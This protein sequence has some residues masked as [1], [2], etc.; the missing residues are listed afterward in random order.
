MLTPKDY[1][2]PF[3]NFRPHQLET[4]LKIKAAF[5]R[6]IKVVLVQAPTGIGKTLLSVLVAM[7]LELDMIYTCHTKT[8]QQQFMKDFRVIGAEELT[9]RANYPC[10][11]NASMFPTISAEQCTRNSPNCKTCELN[12]G[13]CEPDA[14]GYCPC[15]SD[16]PYEIQKR[17]TLSAPIGVLNIPY[18]LREINPVGSFDGKELIILDEA[19]ETENALLSMIELTV[20]ET[21]MKK[22]GLPQLTSKTKPESWREWAAETLGIVNQ[23]LSSLQDKWGAEDLISWHQLSRLKTKLELFVIEADDNWIYDNNNSFKPI[24][25]NRYAEKYLWSHAKRF[26]G[27]SATISPWRQLCHDL[28]VDTSEVEFIDVPSI[29]DVARY[30]IYYQPVANM[31]RDTKEAEIPVLVRAI[32]RIMEQYPDQKGLIHCVSYDNMYRILNL[33]KYPECM[34]HHVDNNRESQ[35]RQFMSSSQPL[36]LLSP[37]M[38]R[39][40]DL[41]DDYC[42]FI[43]IIKVPFPYLGD[44]QIKARLYQHKSDGQTWYNAATVRRI[45]QSTGRGMRSSTDQCVSYILDST[46]EDFYQRNMAMF[47]RW[48][49]DALILTGGDVKLQ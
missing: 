7:M 19:D 37:A 13:G 49:R 29:F 44:P 24:R 4:A 18:F 14:E 3:E 21:I 22:F 17:K 43:V 5:D 42:R 9:G 25:V 46:F 45:V 36:V 35:L 12:K 47:P 38:E 41:P 26:L 23:Q 11:K 28:G 1:G 34:I 39:G 27:I 6:G 33:I 16:C 8:L 2:L 40:V 20:P 10:V 31:G 15:K 30:P 32:D 48:W